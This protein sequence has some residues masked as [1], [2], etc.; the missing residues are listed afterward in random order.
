MGEGRDK[1]GETNELRERET[2]KI[3]K[4]ELVKQLKNF[5]VGLE[6]KENNFAYCF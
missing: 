5:L 3:I 1:K 2:V 6:T 4:K